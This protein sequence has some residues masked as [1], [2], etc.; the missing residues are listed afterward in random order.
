[1]PFLVDI[2]P[3]KLISSAAKK[4]YETLGAE[5]FM[6]D[7]N[8]MMLAIFVAA[9]ILWITEA[10]PNYLYLAHNHNKPD[11]LQRFFL[12]RGAGTAGSPGNV[13]EYHV[14]CPGQYARGN[15]GGKEVCTMV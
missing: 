7:T 9:L 6:R 8:V 13:A 1:M 2:D 5:G 11:P 4:A 10:I 14:V 15:R 3:E 12:R